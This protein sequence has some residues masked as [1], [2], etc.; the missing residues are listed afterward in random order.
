MGRKVSA[1]RT[2]PHCMQHQVA[3]LA[4]STNGRPPLDLGAVVNG[5]NGAGL[6]TGGL[7]GFQDGMVHCPGPGSPAAVPR[8]HFDGSGSVYLD[9]VRSR[10]TDESALDMTGAA[11][12][13]AASQLSG[14][15]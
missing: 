11:I 12:V 10:Q 14:A 1:G 9:D 7:G 5:P 4:G 3:N 6:F 13:A 8:R 15:R 2:F